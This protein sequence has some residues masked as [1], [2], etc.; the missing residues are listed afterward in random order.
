MPTTSVNSRRKCI[1]RGPFECGEDAPGAFYEHA[2]IALCTAVA[3]C[4]HDDC[5]REKPAQ[6]QGKFSQPDDEVV[7]SA[8]D[9]LASLTDSADA[10]VMPAF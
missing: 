8:R 3:T 4:T 10:R 2:G 5:A 1:A 9:C 7:D 6:A